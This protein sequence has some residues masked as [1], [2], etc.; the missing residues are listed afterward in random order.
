M[1]IVTFSSSDLKQRKR[2]TLERDLD[3]LVA[4]AENEILWRANFEKLLYSLK[5]KV[6]VLIFPLFFELTLYILVIH[7]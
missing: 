2:E 3:L 5:I 7:L 4:I 6:Y 1:Y